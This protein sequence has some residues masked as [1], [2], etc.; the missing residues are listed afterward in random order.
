M[1]DKKN[2]V[3]CLAIERWYP[4]FSNVKIEPFPEL[5]TGEIIDSTSLYF[6]ASEGEGDIVL[7]RVVGNGADCYASL[8]FFKKTTKEWKELGNIPGFL[9]TSTN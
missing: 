9:F 6:N 7:L 2:M 8:Y 3:L 1:L 4:D 5:T